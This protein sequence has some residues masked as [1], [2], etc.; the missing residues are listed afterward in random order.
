LDPESR[1]RFAVAAYSATS[2]DEAKGTSGELGAKWDGGNHVFIE[3]TGINASVGGVVDVDG[4]K[5]I[6]EAVI[7]YATS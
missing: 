5:T 1:V 2:Y 4:K 3:W 7:P 6:A